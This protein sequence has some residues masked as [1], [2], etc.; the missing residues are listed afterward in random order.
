MKK[1]NELIKPYNETSDEIFFQYLNSTLVF[2][3]IYE[4]LKN[5]KCKI[6]K[7]ERGEKS[8][9]IEAICSGDMISWYSWPLKI[10]IKKELNGCRVRI[11]AGIYQVWGYPAKRRVNNI[12]NLLKAVIDGEQPKQKVT[13]STHFKLILPA[14]FIFL[15][16]IFLDWM[17][18]AHFGGSPHINVIYGMALK[19]GLI[20]TL[21]I[22]PFFVS[23]SYFKKPLRKL[24]FLPLIYFL[25]CII[26]D[27][28]R[29]FYC[30]GSWIIY[31]VYWKT[32]LFYLLSIIY[33][34]GFS[35]ILHILWKKVYPAL[36]R[37]TG[38][39]IA[40]YIFFIIIIST[41]VSFSSF[42]FSLLVEYTGG[43]EDR[44]LVINYEGL[45]TEEYLNVPN[46]EVKIVCGNPEVSISRNFPPVFTSLDYSLFVTEKGIESNV[47]IIRFCVG[48]SVNVLTFSEFSGIYSKFII[49]DICDEWTANNIINKYSASAPLDSNWQEID[50]NH[51]VLKMSRNKYNPP[52]LHFVKKKCGPNKIA[53]FQS[54]KYHPDLIKNFKCY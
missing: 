14:F 34:F 4:I 3:K 10:N 1:I 41:A 15:F 46:Y 26:G 16:Y 29:S 11:T 24:W 53:V 25:F 27:F 31:S 6:I 54:I 18:L 39:S 12:L 47:S 36:Q 13:I 33:F 21:F 28:F 38:V 22:F 5:K 35:L 52:E 51:Y 23:L 9:Y 40:F 30:S 42:M 37:K 48:R 20:G 45:R 19:F 17:T 44:G 7:E 50:E 2:E 49:I 32:I 43:L 8:I